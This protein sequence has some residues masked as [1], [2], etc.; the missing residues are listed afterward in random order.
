MKDLLQSLR[1]QVNTIDEELV[2]LLFR[3]FEI[4]K[5]I[6]A[7]AQAE[8]LDLLDKQRKQELL[9]IMIEE[10]KD[11]WVDQDMVQEIYQIIQK[12]SDKISK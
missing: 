11:K 2:Y 1:N 12:Y 7:L 5:E 10:A 4:V 3:R 8:N 6:H 9:D